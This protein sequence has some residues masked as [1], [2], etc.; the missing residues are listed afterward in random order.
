METYNSEKE[1]LIEQF[2]YLKNFEKWT[3]DFYRQVFYN[4]RVESQEV[5]NVFSR[6]ALDEDR[7]AEIV[8]KIINIINNN[9]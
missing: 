5:K 2:E 9:L 8:Q 1:K 3:G 7:H 4:P 6:I